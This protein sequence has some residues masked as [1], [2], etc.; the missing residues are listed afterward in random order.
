M[1]SGLDDKRANPSMVGVKTTAMLLRE[2]AHLLVSFVVVYIRPHPKQLF[3]FDN[4][5]VLI[6]FDPFLYCT[7]KSFHECPRMCE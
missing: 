3:R 2:C 6:G 1:P 7:G 4:V 5:D